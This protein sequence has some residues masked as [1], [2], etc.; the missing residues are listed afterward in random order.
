[1]KHKSGMPFYAFQTLLVAPA[2]RDSFLTPT[3]HTLQK[4]KHYTFRKWHNNLLSYQTHILLSYP[5]PHL[6]ELHQ[7]TPYWATPAHTFLSYPTHTLLSYPDPHLTE[8]SDPHLTELPQPTTYWATQPITYWDTPAHIILIYPDPRPTETPRPTPY[9]ATRP[10]TYWATPTNTLLSYT[11]PH[12]TELS[13]PTPHHFSF[14]K[15]L[16]FVRPP[17]TLL[18]SICRPNNKTT[19]APAKVDRWTE[20]NMTAKF[21]VWFHQIT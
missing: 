15:K 17:Y 10:T 2:D 21:A 3:P 4:M 18:R 8:L 14:I 7:P 20:Y 16:L 9:W 19:N 1:M 13:R 5:G 11:D 12:L 6:T